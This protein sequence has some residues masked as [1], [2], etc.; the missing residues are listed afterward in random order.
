MPC[1][2][3]MKKILFTKTGI[4]KEV[5][6]KLGTEFSCDFVEVIEFK[7]H[8]IEKFD[9]KDSAVIF[10][11]QNAV[12]G[13]VENGFSLNKENK[14]Y[15]VGDK[16]K[17]LVEKNFNNKTLSFKNAKELSAFLKSNS[18]NENF[19]HFCGNLSIEI[20][21]KNEHYKKIELY[22]TQFLEPKIEEKYDVVCF[23][24]PSGVRSFAKL[25]SLEG[26]EIFLIGKT[27]ERELKKLT[28]NKIFTSLENS[29]EDLLGLINS[30][31]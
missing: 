22:E 12:K 19:I 15:C 7:F 26:F 29:L 23:F 27:T 1:A 5:S 9:L 18:E 24:S 2:E 6:E 3:I 8:K 21:E 30:H 31:E 17:T 11:S 25:N 14:I 16:T 28:K 4:E 10:T 13:F 20:L